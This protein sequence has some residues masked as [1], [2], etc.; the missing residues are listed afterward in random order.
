MYKIAGLILLA[1]VGLL[2]LPY[3]LYGLLWL[4]TGRGLPPKSTEQLGHMQNHWRAE[5]IWALKTVG[6]AAIGVGLYKATTFLW[7]R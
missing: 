5:E 3:L 7:T 6:M 1:L 4:A 2:S